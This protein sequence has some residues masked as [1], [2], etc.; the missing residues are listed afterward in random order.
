[1]ARTNRPNILWYC[2][3]QQRFDTI[4][5]L[6]NPHVRT[7]TLDRLVREGMAFTHTYCQSPICTPSR[8]SFMSGLYPSRLHNTRNGNDTFPSSPPLVSTLLADSGY[9]C[10]LIGKFHLQSSGHRTEPRIANDGFR[11]WKFSHAPRDDWPAG[12]HDYADWVRDQ[13][14]D[15]NALRESE[16]RVPAELHQTTWATTRAIEFIDE[17][18]DG[19]PWMLNINVYDPHPPFIPPRSYAEEFDESEMPGPSFVESDLEA[20]AALEDADFQTRSRRPEEFDGKRVQAD[21]YAMIA[22]IDDQLAR[23]LA[24][25]EKSGEAENTVVIFTS[26]HGETLGDH[27]LLYKGCRFY[28]GLVRVPLIFHA[29]GRIVEGVTSDQLTELLDLSATLLDLAD[30]P[31]PDYHQGHS[32]LPHLTGEQAPETPVR[33]FVRCEYFDALAPHFTGGNGT[34]ATM[35]RSGDDKLVLYHSLNKG[36]LFDLASDPWEHQNLWDSP[37]HADRK[38]QLILES[39]HAHVNLTTDVG[40]ERIA[41]M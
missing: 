9:D 34:F 27:G 21:Y 18:R 22:L 37:E 2:T 40:S 24:H 20:Q 1:M 36:E 38:N 13:G 39:F 14:A 23:L 6:G 8:S 29:P 30:V 25:L 4:G 7:P 16:D 32:L 26:D 33:E 31:V 5:A 11:Y 41:P 19:K 12:E 3:D 28:E 10:G 15:L 17:D 35:H